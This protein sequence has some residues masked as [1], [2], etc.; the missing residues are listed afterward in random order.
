MHRP[1][2]A[3]TSSAAVATTGHSAYQ[4]NHAGS[5]PTIDG[6]SPTDHRTWLMAKPERIDVASVATSS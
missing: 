4:V 1:A 6:A 2:L 5:S 3:S